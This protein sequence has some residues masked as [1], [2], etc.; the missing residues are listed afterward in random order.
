[1]LASGEPIEKKQF[2]GKYRLVCELGRGGMGVVYLAEDSLLSRHVALKL[3]PPILVATGRLEKRF[4]REAKSAASLSHPPI[5][6]LHAFDVIDGTPAIEMEYMPV[7]S[8]AQW[9]AREA[10]TLQWIVRYCQQVA[11][12]LAYCHGLGAI[13]RD[14]KPANILLNDYKQAKLADFGVAKMFDDL[15]P[16]SL[17]VSQSGSFKGT[18]RYVPPEAWSGADATPLWDVYALGVV[19]YECLTGS[20]PYAGESPLELARSIALSPIVPTRDRNPF[21]SHALGELVDQMLQ[22]QPEERITTAGEVAERLE[23]TPE[24]TSAPSEETVAMPRERLVELNSGETQPPRIRRSHM[25]ALATAALLTISSLLTGW[26]YV[27]AA[28]PIA[29]GEVSGKAPARSA[30]AAPVFDAIL[31]ASGHRPEERW[32]LTLDASGLPTHILAQ[33]PFMLSALACE[34]RGAEFA[35][36][37][38]WAGFADARGTVYRSGSVA[39]RGR[40][41]GAPPA[42]VGTLNYVSE[43]DGAQEQVTFVAA[44]RRPPQDVAQ[45]WAETAQSEYLQPLLFRELLPRRLGWAQAFDEGLVVFAGDYLRLPIEDPHTTPAAIDG[46]LAE[47]VWARAFTGPDST[48]IQLRGAPEHAASRLALVNTGDGIAL[49]IRLALP[50]SVQSPVVDLRVLSNFAVPLS[51]SRQLQ[52]IVRDGD[53]EARLL[54]GAEAETAP[55]FSARFAALQGERYWELEGLLPYGPALRRPQSGDRW[56][57]S[58]RVYRAG[59]GEEAIV[60]WGDAE[61]TDAAKGAVIAFDSL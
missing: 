6:H 43:Q 14:V 8:L 12:A 29:R 22:P 28:S 47:A 18:P 1:L 19:L 5:V 15:V 27:G 20:L 50:S 16:D 45:F 41:L 24:F 54:T 34:D 21:I 51:K 60:V 58:G 49:G 46:L 31:Q 30:P 55:Q 35:L 11:T 48:G 3:L 2:I 39:G 44:S 56:R 32:L 9:L 10:V 37:G 36:Q 61:G 7:G 4:L 13:H 42:L 57:I 59:E 17:T 25:L 53:Y 52:V 38:A 33:S 40:W 26:L 23:A